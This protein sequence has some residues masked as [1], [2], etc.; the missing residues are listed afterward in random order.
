MSTYDD[1][2]PEF[3]N[4]NGIAC[5]VIRSINWKKN[6]AGKIS[7]WPPE[8]L[9]TVSIIVNSAIPML[10]IWGEKHTVFFND[11]AAP[12]LPDEP[13]KI[14][15]ATA[16]DVWKENWRVIS[17]HV[18]GVFKTGA[19]VTVR[20]GH[21]NLFNL[22]QASET[23]ADFI[24]HF[25]AVRNLEG[26]VSGVLI[27]INKQPSVTYEP[28]ESDGNLKHIHDRKKVEEERDKIMRDLIGRNNN[29]K[30]FSYIVS[31]NLR[32]PINRIL[33]LA[34][35]FKN[36]KDDAGQ[37]Q[38]LIQYIENEA[39]N[40]NNVVKDLTTIV[41]YQ[42]LGLAAREDIIFEDE[43]KIILQSL[44]NEITRS[45]ALITSDFQSAQKFKSVR[46][47]FYS[48]LYNLLSNAIK[49]GNPA[50]PLKIHV[51][52]THIENYLCLS[53]SDNGLGIDLDKHRDE[54]FG[55]YSR[56]HALVPG[57]GMGLNLVKTQ[58]ETLGGKIQV[59]SSPNI[60]STFFI[61]LPD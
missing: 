56:F 40:L 39:I 21:S 12:L 2:I 23:S 41:S 9:N 57:K 43:L 29:L 13:A 30:Q 34:A 24:S 61:Y 48:I 42:D 60:G 59:D 36:E 38:M 5:T 55:L 53:V 32:S 28:S 37:K 20:T 16:A 17:P 25:S 45:Q 54:L 50:K 1:P 15:G 14:M 7:F 49:F 26:R 19:P 4:S 58:V 6:P 11:A 10:L 46:G 35:I 44:E 3:L 51:K 8:L 33:G 52:T 22:Y 47:Y 27:L 18:T 31:H